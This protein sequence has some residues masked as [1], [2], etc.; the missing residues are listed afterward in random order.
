[1][2]ERL[3][4]AS[5]GRDRP[6]LDPEDFA[7][8]LLDPALGAPW[9]TALSRPGIATAS[10]SNLNVAIE[11]GERLIEGSACDRPA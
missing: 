2:N 5:R 9:E 7:P 11:M 1:M 6:I 8:V 4:T 10:L 3:P